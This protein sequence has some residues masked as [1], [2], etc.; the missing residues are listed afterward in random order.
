[1]S[2]WVSTTGARRRMSLGLSN[3]VLGFGLASRVSVLRLS[4]FLSVSAVGSST[5]GWRRRR[6]RRE[7]GF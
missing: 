7:F 3:W 5:M 4:E 6:R 1:M 2:V